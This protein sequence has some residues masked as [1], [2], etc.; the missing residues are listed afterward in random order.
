[1]KKEPILKIK[2]KD[3][4]GQFRDWP[5]MISHFGK[6]KRTTRSSGTQPGKILKQN[7]DP[8]G[9]PYVTFSK[10]NKT[11]V[12]Y[13]HKLVAEIFIGPC[14]EGKQ[15]NH[16][17]GSK[18]NNYY[19]NLEYVTPKQNIRHAI[20]LGLSNNKGERNGQAELT[21]KD[22]KEIRKKYKTGQYTQKQLANLYGMSAG[23]ISDII[24]CVKWRD[25]NGK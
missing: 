20:R 6:V 24:R 1:M 16:I 17:D 23:H 4:W 18:Q 21:E 19:K 2:I 12:F 9:Y 5:Y 3:R 13:V 15:V 11:K 8:G 25:L 14:P 7:L 22:V 10:N